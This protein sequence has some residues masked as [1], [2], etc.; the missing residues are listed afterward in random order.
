M[1]ERKTCDVEGC[2]NRAVVHLEKVVNGHQS[3]HYYC[4][5]CAAEKGIG[6]TPSAFDIGEI[7]AQMGAEAAGGG[8]ETEA[9]GFCGLGHGDFKKTGRLGCPECYGSFEAKLRKL[10]RRIHGSDQHA[11]KVYLPPGPVADEAGR[12]RALRGRLARAVAAEDFE[13]AATL[14]DVIRSIEAQPPAAGDAVAAVPPAG[15]R[16]QGPQ[17]PPAPMSAGGEKAGGGR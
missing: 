16:P 9:C 5:G 1:P 12:L 3:H 14:R 10:L 13:Q 15:P 8:D 2:G 6:P 11:G 7:L 4:E 17:G